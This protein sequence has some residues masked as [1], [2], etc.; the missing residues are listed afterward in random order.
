L[1]YWEINYLYLNANS[2]EQLSELAKAGEVGV[3]I[4]LVIA[5]VVI[6]RD[7][8]KMIKNH[9]EHN[10]EALNRQS[11]K[12]EEFIDVIKEAMIQK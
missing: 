11:V 3:S 1:I 2:M 7:V 12:M 6:V 9:M 8:L 5:I 4:V 10:T